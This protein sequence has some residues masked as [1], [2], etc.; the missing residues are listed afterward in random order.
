MRNICC[1]LLYEFLSD[2]DRPTRRL[3]MG[4]PVLQYLKRPWSFN[5]SLSL[6]T[7]SFLSCTFSL[8]LDLISHR[9][10]RR[11]LSLAMFSAPCHPHHSTHSY[12][13]QEFAVAPGG[14]LRTA[15]GF[16]TCTS[17]FVITRCIVVVV[18]LIAASA[19]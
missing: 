1:K 11:I 13:P 16:K 4:L 18:C 5:F 10:R 15:L 3:T 17:R 19:E 6:K 7:E 8:L 12:A 14:V 2:H 9:Q